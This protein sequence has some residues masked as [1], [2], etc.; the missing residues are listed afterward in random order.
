[1]PMQ[2]FRLQQ[3]GLKKLKR[4]LLIIMLPLLLIYAIVLPVAIAGT[5]FF[6]D[7]ANSQ[8]VWSTEMIIPLVIIVFFYG[9]TIFSM[10]RFY[11]R[12]KRMYESYELQISDNL[13]GREQANTPAISIYFKDVEEIVKR[14]NGTF[15]V[16]GATATDLIFIPKYIEN[17]EQ[18]ET[19]LGQIK[20][21]AAKSKKTPPYLIQFILSLAMVGLM[22]CIN[23]VNNKVIVA[24]AGLSLTALVIYN[25]IQTRKSKNV[26][27]RTKRFRWMS[28]IVLLLF[29]YIVFQKL[30]APE[31]P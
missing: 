5:G 30:T 12:T 7:I 4:R 15:M 18:L 16:R 10:T 2:S 24:I 9:L 20:P 19:A 22:V 26:D 28:F 1:M 17:Y 6:T 14:K 21:I 8:F 27:Y 13:I 31:M 29:L 23:T 25:F 11:S 3:D